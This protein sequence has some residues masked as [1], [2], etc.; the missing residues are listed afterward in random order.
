MKPF[1]EFNAFEFVVSSNG[2]K[3]SS[4]ALVQK[5]KKKK[6]ALRPISTDGH[7]NTNRRC[8]HNSMI[9]FIFAPFGLQLNTKLSNKADFLL[10]NELIAKSDGS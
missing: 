7:I 4:G 9:H 8:I 5:N 10:A 3:L 2:T 1:T 6:N